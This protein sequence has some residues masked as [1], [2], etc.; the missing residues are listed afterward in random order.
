MA[1][2]NIGAGHFD[3]AKK[4]MQVGRNIA[5]AIG[6]TIFC[7]FQLF[8]GFFIGIFTKDAASIEYGTAYIRAFSFDYLMVPF[9]FCAAGLLTG[10]GNTMFV[11]FASIAC[12]LVLRIPVA[13]VLAGPAGLGLFGIGLA[14]PIGSFGNYILA[15]VFIATGRWKHSK[16]TEPAEASE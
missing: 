8:P 6:A 12:S 7:L 9:A 16:I 4:T 1:G 15:A 2:Q 10:A 14:V 13:Q 5:L 11:A 3:R